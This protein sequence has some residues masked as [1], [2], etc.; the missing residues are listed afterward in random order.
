MQS[1]LFHIYEIMSVYSGVLFPATT[2]DTHPIDGVYNVLDFMCGESLSTVQLPRVAEEAKPYIEEQLPLV[3]DVAAE[4][5]RLMGDIA[6]GGLADQFE[7]IAVR[8]CG[9]YG[10]WHTLIPM[11][12]EDHEVISPVQDARLLGFTGEILE[13][14][15]DE[16]SQFGD[17]PPS[18]ND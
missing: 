6:Y 18:E 13:I 5:K 16:P 9:N 10:T 15:L 14:N 12:P 11:H 1:K 17:L 7:A 4:L 8:V 2:E 3:K